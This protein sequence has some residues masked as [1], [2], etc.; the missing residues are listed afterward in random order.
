MKRE[1]RLDRVCGQRM[2]YERNRHRVIYSQSVCGICGLPVDKSLKYPNQMC[3]TVDHIIPLN[4]GGTNEL[5]NL[6]LA[7]RFCNRQ[8]SDKLYVVDGLPVK[9]PEHKK[10]RNIQQ[11]IDWSNYGG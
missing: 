9:Q 11:Y 8:K 10:N 1:A 2:V 3:A 5:S 4:K 7:H 6:Q